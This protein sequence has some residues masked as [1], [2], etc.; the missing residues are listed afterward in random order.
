M[1]YAR[2]GTA[3]QSY[4]CARLLSYDIC[5]FKDF[6]LIIKK[7]FQPAPGIPLAVQCVDNVWIFLQKQIQ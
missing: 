5:F 4:C 1:N 7:R 2:T 6:L 3:D